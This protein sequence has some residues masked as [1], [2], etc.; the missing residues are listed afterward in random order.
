[1]SVTLSSAEEDETRCVWT[2]SRTR[3][4]SRPTQIGIW[5]VL[6]VLAVILPLFRQTGTRSWQ[7][8][9]SEDGSIYF[10]QASL[11]GGISVLFRGYAG[12]LQLPPRLL[13]VVS[14]HVPIHDLSIYMALSGTVTDAL[15]AWFL[16]HFSRGW[17]TSRPVRLALASLLVL[18]PA[19]GDEN[20]ANITD[21]IW[22]FAAVAPWALISVE[23]RHR[24]VVI[25]S[26]VAFLAAA[27]TSL[28]V[29]FL[30]LALGYASIRKTRATWIVTAVFC[31]GLAVQAT[32]VMHTRSD[33]RHDDFFRHSS[34]LVLVKTTAVRVFAMFLI[35]PKGITVLADHEA[36]LILGSTFCMGVIFGVLLP[37]TSQMS[38][39]VAVILVAYTV[40]SFAATV[41]YRNYFGSVGQQYFSPNRYSVIPVMLLASGVAILVTP[42]G[43][44]R[45]RIGRYLF[46]SYALLL[47][48]VGF[49][50]T[51]VRS[52]SPNWSASVGR[53]YV[54]D[55]LG[56]APTRS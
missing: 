53:A 33:A 28:C 9:W 19:L 16:Y 42:V 34:L 40:I 4:E 21:T 47:I 3:I 8:I 20:T 12:Y 36:L 17:I 11:H 46:V 38:R 26:I 50:V 18:M 54:S 55:C 51:N 48:L 1:M 13:A 45:T 44:G 39:S 27:S 56:P 32:V 23:E 15:L 30:P 25:R 2:H 6:F 14:T 5:L 24:E 35:G 41:W 10:S 49:S 7:T 43:L 52:A 37:G 22:V 29:I 31:A